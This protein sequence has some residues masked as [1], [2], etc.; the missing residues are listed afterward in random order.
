MPTEWLVNSL[1]FLIVGRVGFA[2]TVMLKQAVVW[3]D[4]PLAKSESEH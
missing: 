2:A 1:F 4:L 3:K